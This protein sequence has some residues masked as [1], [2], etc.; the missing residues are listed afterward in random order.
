MD[1]W[2]WSRL[3]AGS[4]AV[5]IGMINTG[6][7]ALCRAFIK[8]QTLS[9]QTAGYVI[10]SAAEY[11]RRYTD[12]LPCDRVYDDYEMDTS[13]II[14]RIKGVSSLQPPPAF[15]IIDDCTWDPA[16]LKGPWFTQLL[17][18]CKSNRITLLLTT[19][20]AMGLPPRITR[21]VDAVFVLREC[22]AANRRRIFDHYGIGLR[23]LDHLCE[24]MAT[25]IE[26]YHKSGEGGC[27]VLTS[28]A[29]YCWCVAPRKVNPMK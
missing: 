29:Q 23:D 9:D 1:P 3:P 25:A 19:P 11:D 20:Y 2:N 18:Y 6:K 7:T 17:R 14:M 24:A 26:P 4:F 16:I 12:F 8:A 22:H 5:A 28:T 21:E 13:G 27:L 10:H 15:V